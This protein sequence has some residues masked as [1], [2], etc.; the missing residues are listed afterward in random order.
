MPAPLLPPGRLDAAVGADLFAEFLNIL[1][2][3]GQDDSFS[4]PVDELQAV[5]PDIVLQKAE[6]PLN[7]PLADPQPVR[8]LLF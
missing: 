5:M 7:G 3:P 6:F 4:L 1:Q 2:F 8:D